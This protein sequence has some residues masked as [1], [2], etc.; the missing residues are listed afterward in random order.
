MKLI[1]MGL[2]ASCLFASAFAQ[3]Q[4][5]ELGASGLNISPFAQLSAKTQQAGASLEYLI[6]SRFLIGASYSWYLKDTLYAGIINDD[7]YIYDQKSTTTTIPYPASFN[8]RID[9]LSTIVPY[10]FN[11][12][13]RVMRF[14]SGMEILEPDRINPLSFSL[15]T[16]FTKVHVNQKGISYTVIEIEAEP[17]DSLLILVTPDVSIFTYN[18]V[19]LDIGLQAGYRFYAGNN[20]TI[21]PLLG[22]TFHYISEERTIGEKSDRSEPIWNDISFLVPSSYMFNETLGI[23]FNPSLVA[24]LGSQPSLILFGGVSLGLIVR[25]P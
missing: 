1:R 7:N 15:T 16:G 13:S 12:K 4:T 2:L 3:V 9:P 10:T 23:S 18:Q 14:Y 11:G 19:G 8:Y 20:G 22:Y 6:E 17:V 5:L 24:R 21:T 25:F